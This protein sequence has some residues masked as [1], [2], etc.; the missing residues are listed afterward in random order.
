MSGS[1]SCL[2]QPAERIR[3]LLEDQQ[4]VTAASRCSF[5]ETFDE[6]S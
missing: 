1:D 3:N 4:L 2:K 5:A 6:T